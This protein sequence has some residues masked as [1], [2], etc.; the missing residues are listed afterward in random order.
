MTE[1]LTEPKDKEIDLAA[2][3]TAL[4]NRTTESAESLGKVTESQNRMTQPPEKTPELQSKMLESQ[5]PRER[6]I[7]RVN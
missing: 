4:S 3:A 7:I 5:T 1:P 6:D 2:R